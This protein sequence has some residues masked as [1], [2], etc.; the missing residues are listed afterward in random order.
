MPMSN[1]ALK[2]PTI[3]QCDLTDVALPIKT[4]SWKPSISRMRPRSAEFPLAPDARAPKPT[5]TPLARRQLGDR[6]PDSTDDRCDHHLC[7][8]VAAMDRERLL[9]VIDQNNADSATKVSIYG[10]GSVH[11]RDAVANGEAG[12]G[13]YLGLVAGGEADAEAGGDQGAVAGLEH[14]IVRD[15]GVEVHAGGIGSGVGGKRQ[16]LALRSA[17]NR[18]A[19]LHARLLP[20][21]R[22]AQACLRS[23]PARSGPRPSAT[24]SRRACPE[25]A[26]TGPGCRGRGCSARAGA[27]DA[28]RCTVRRWSASSADIPCV[29]R[30]PNRTSIPRSAGSRID[31]RY[32]SR[33]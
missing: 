12:A 8:S 25:S 24:R 18:D 14:D 17:R 32:G 22:V 9:P 20:P 4:I 33:P 1:R 28:D 5:L 16:A 15:G 10:P 31:V 30:D 27:S 26:R 21:P 19:D 2:A 7:N 29:G 23:P 11:H 3:N 13:P 6:L